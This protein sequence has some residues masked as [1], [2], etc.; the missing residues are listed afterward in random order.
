MFRVTGVVPLPST[1]AIKYGR[2]NR[3]DRMERMAAL[4]FE[5]CGVPHSVFTQ[6]QL[7]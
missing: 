7:S 1:M 6:K 4:K 3:I 2:K 5:R